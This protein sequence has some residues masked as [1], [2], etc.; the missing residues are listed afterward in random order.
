[1]STILL[2]IDPAL[3]RL[4]YDSLS[5]QALMEMLIDGMEDEYK[6][7]FQDKSGNFKDLIDWPGIQLHGDRVI[8]I[9]MWYRR[10]CDK[11]FPFQFIP[12]MVKGLFIE[13]CNAH[14]TLGTSLL[15]STFIRLDARGNYLHTLLAFKN[16]PQDF[17]PSIHSD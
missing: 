16:S 6:K 7:E 5:D 12:E 8:C 2:S 10:F 3:G 17:P 15:P 14:G 9:T 13:H 4:D 1:M 11:Q